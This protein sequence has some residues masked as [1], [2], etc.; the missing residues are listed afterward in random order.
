[1]TQSPMIS[2][3]RNNWRETVLICR[4]CSKKVHGGF[5]DKSR[6]RL[7]KALQKA[8]NLRKGRRAEI[9]IIE[10]GCFD[11]CPKKAVTVVLGSAPGAYQIIPE[12]TPVEAVIEALDL[13]HPFADQVPPT[14]SAIQSTDRQDH[15]AELS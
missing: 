8:L 11:I 12:G 7:S 9:G 3:R 2:Q 1:M 15:D 14:K 5:G 6:K 13:S 4:K 10:V